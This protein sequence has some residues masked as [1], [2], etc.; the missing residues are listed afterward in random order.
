[1]AKNSMSHSHCVAVRLG[2]V[3]HLIVTLETTFNCQMS[4]RP[5]VRYAKHKSTVANELEMK[6]QFS[7]NE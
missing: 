6:P 3:N 1:M 4:M 2:N 7:K 5:N